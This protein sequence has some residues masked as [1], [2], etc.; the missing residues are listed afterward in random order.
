MSHYECLENV[1]FIPVYSTYSYYYGYD[2]NLPVVMSNVS[3][4]GN[5]S[6]LVDCSYSTGGSGSPVSLRCSYAS[7][8]IKACGS[9]TTFVI[10]IAA[11]CN[12]GDL[13]LTGGHSESE[14]RVEFCSSRSLWGTV[15]RNQWTKD[16]SNVVCRSLGYDDEG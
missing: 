13:R 1:C 10:F 5:E 7:K 11:S 16:N 8:N 6:R 12:Y 9:Y 2:N 4:D 14:G 15:C 3:C